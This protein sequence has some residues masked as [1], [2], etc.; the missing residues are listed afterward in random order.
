LR[1]NAAHRLRAALMVAI[2]GLMRIETAIIDRRQPISAVIGIGQYTIIE[3]V[4]IGIITEI[5]RRIAADLLC[6]NLVS[7]IIYWIIVVISLG[8]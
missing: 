1:G 2:V 7:S 3:Q 8:R 4:A 6:G 5:R